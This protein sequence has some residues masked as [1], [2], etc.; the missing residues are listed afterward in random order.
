MM[1]QSSQH[2]QLTE[3]LGQSPSLPSGPRAKM[4]EPPTP[5]NARGSPQHMSLGATAHRPWDR[6]VRGALVR[7]V[8]WGWEI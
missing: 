7:K 8:Q 4:Q 2:G 5:P 1:Q 3:V 6:T